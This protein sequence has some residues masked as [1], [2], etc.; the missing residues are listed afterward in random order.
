M[1]SSAYQS[2]FKFNLS[3][4]LILVIVGIVFLF[5][6]ILSSLFVVDQTEEAVILR[7]GK[8]IKIA[9]PGL[10]TKLPFG[11]DRNYNIPTKVVQTMNFG[12]NSYS[13]SSFMTRPSGSSAGESIMLTGDLNIIDLQWVIQYRIEDPAKWLFN[14]QER[15]KTIRDISQSVINQLV[16][17]LPILAIMS[18]ER[19]AIEIESQE[20]MQ[21]TFDSY[22]LGVRIVTVKLQNIVPPI[23]EVQDAFEDVNKA[24]QDMNRLINEGKEQYN[25]E[26]PRAQGEASQ[27][28][29]VAE[30][31]AAERV[32]NAIGDVQRFSSV[33]EA[34]SL[35]K[36]ITA[37][38]LYIETLEEIFGKENADN[39]T[40][41]DKELEN[42]L[43]ISNLGGAR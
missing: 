6:L 16:G 25:R 27:M 15:D 3:P 39:I 35:S 9:G 23:G 20:R 12:Q 32:N 19:T 37:Q 11:I 36:E 30:G 10:Q 26:I 33:R 1:S 38:R 5:L 14:V 17:D 21:S 43:P 18:S 4:K 28:L 24:I 41:I 40:L 7:F 42:F 13:Q 8:F 34:Y 31:Y 29:Q 22:D 2:R